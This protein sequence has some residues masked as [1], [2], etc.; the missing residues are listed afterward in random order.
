MPNAPRVWKSPTTLLLFSLVFRAQAPKQSHD[1]IS[2]GQRK[3]HRSQNSEGG[4]PS[5]PIGGTVVP[6]GETYLSS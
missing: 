3:P 1:G 6:G 4:E 5:S 2:S